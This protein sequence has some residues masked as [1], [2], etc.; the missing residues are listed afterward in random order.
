MVKLL[1]EG[2]SSVNFPD[3]K[4]NTALHLAACRRDTRILQILSQAT[5]P[6]PDFNAK[7]F[8]GMVLCL[9]VCVCV[10][11]CVHVYIYVQVL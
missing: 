3:R 9:F 7:N 5:S 1:V 11:V 4:G 2:G 6:L 10:H 8:I